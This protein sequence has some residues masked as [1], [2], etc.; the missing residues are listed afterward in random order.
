MRIAPAQIVQ[1]Q[2]ESMK[3]RMWERI[4]PSKKKRAWRIH[5][6]S[7]K[8]SDY[9]TA[10]L[11]SE[12]VVWKRSGDCETEF[13]TDECLIHVQG[14]HHKN[15]AWLLEPMAIN[16]HVYDWISENAEKFRLILTHNRALLD[17]F[18]NAKF[19]PA[20]G[21]WVHKKDHQ[22]FKKTKNISIIASSKTL[23]EG[24]R[25]RHR[26]VSQHQGRIDAFGGGYERIKNKIKGLK[27]YR[28]SLAIEN[29]REDYYFTEKLIDCFVTGTV[30][31]YY[32]CPSISDYFDTRGM[33]LINSEND[34][35]NIV[36]EL[37]DKHYSSMMPYI[38]SNFEEAK[39]YIIAEDFIHL[40]YGNQINAL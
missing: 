26:I 24:H 32:G 34:F 1:N 10:H 36:D 5:D 9:T 25:L 37:N 18:P 30:P 22:I 16:A 33:I 35:T 19:V 20:G 27:R 17:R 2:T 39:K 7:F 15:I 14:A 23:T 6:E 12:Y 29:S 40:N 13:Y 28:F 31:V 8:H 11:S 3:A 38:R 21:C 4:F